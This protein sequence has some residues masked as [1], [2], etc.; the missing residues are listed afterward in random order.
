MDSW[1]DDL[2]PPMTR[3]LPRS[4]SPPMSEEMLEK[5]SRRYVWAAVV[6]VVPQLKLAKKAHGC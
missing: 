6:V 4:A 1:P 2:S 5:S 3:P